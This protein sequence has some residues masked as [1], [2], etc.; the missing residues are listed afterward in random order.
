MSDYQRYT[1]LPVRKVFEIA[2][3]ILPERAG[4]ER[5]RASRHS[6][7][8]TGQEGTVTLDA[9]RHGVATDVIARTNQLRTSKLDG[10]VRFL[11]NQLP[12]QPGDPPRE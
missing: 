5:T 2:D 1:V 10:A 8:Y 12:Y 6:V 7:T 9:H 11:F 3:E 4:V